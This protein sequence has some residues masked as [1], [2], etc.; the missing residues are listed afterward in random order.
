M[1]RRWLRVNLL[2]T[3]LVQVFAIALTASM[4][5]SCEKKSTV[6]SV[7]LRTMLL[8]RAFGT[9]IRKIGDQSERFFT[10]ANRK[11][12]IKRLR[13]GAHTAKFELTKGIYSEKASGGGGNGVVRARGEW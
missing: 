4:F 5:T 11:H 3:R 7:F 10:W 13:W 1:K 2:K 6:V 8:I 12:E 9:A